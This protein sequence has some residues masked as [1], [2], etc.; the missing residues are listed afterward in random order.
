MCH[1]RLLEMLAIYVGV[2]LC[3]M[4]I[5]FS[6][7]GLGLSWDALNHHIYLGW[8]A[9]EWRFDKDYF[10][11]SSQSYQFPYS[12]WIIYKLST[13]GIS[14]LC[15]GLIWS[16]INALVVLP[17]WLI[18]AQLFPGGGL[19]SACLRILSIL[20]G[21]GNLLVLRAPETTSNDILVSVPWLFAV[22][23]ALGEAG[24]ANW[25]GK[26]VGKGRAFLVGWLGG[27]AIA[28]KLSMAVVSIF[29]PIV[30]LVLSPTRKAK[31]LSGGFC[32]LG[33]LVGFLLLYGAWGWVLWREFG[34]PFYPFVDAIFSPI[35]LMLNWRRG[36]V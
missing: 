3:F 12:Y 28:L 34:N 5:P 24:G 10:A 18:A 7:G 36:G 23:L 31:V 19:N 13:L 15:V 32:I 21:C 4:S 8:V 11:A 14:G 16:A 22:A 26:W 17:L 25:G 20:F 30:F 9:N 6:L 1:R 35:R 27:V 33:L 2:S 29:L